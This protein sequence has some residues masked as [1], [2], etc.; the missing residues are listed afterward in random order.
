MNKEPI[1]WS[2]F[3]TPSLSDACE[4]SLKSTSSGQ[5]QMISARARVIYRVCSSEIMEALESRRA[6][7]DEEVQCLGADGSKHWRVPGS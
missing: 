3:G 5:R 4:P 7:T 6:A 1:A 2:I